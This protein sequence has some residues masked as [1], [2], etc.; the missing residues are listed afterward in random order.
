[1]TNRDELLAIFVA[2]LATT[3]DHNKEAILYEAFYLWK[4]F[5]RTVNQEFDSVDSNFTLN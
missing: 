2:L 5:D 4:V 3:S 1:M